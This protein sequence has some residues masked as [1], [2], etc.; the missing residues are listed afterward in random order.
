MTPKMNFFVLAMS[1][2][3][4]S[5]DSRGGWKT[6]FLGVGAFNLGMG[7]LALFLDF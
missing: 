2:F 5:I 6:F 1:N 7:F 3:L 4:L